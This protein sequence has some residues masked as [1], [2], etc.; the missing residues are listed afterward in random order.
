M[1]SPS[2]RHFYA[3]EEMHSV[4]VGPGSPDS[5]DS[6]QHIDPKFRE[7]LETLYTPAAYKALHYYPNTFKPIF[8]L[9]S[10]PFSKLEIFKLEDDTERFVP[11]VSE[12]S[13][14]PYLPIFS[15]AQRMVR[16]IHRN[17]LQNI[18]ARRTED[19]SSF[20]NLGFACESSIEWGSEPGPRAGPPRLM[21]CGGANPLFR[22]IVLKGFYPHF[23]NRSAALDEIMFFFTRAETDCLALVTV[24]AD[25]RPKA[26]QFICDN[27]KLQ[28]FDKVCA[29]C[30]KTGNDLFK[31]PCKAVR[32]C[33]A[34]CQ[35]AHWAQHRDVC[36]WRVGCLKE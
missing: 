25:E 32:Y 3:H 26:I 7:M 2:P 35:R 17:V 33:C 36:E 19:V 8:K 30:G 22:R 12:A 31:C 4:G 6:Y 11:V 15:A 27:G 14:S 16:S 20:V 24:P 21:N 9:P 29:Q 10:L 13:R 18:V 28:L 23:C 1:A 5:W 34:E